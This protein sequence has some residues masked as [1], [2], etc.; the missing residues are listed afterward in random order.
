MFGTGP[1]G[2][3]HI[4]AMRWAVP[5]IEE[6]LLVGR[7]DPCPTDL[8]VVCTCT[9]S[10]VAVL[11]ESSLS[12]GSHCNLVGSYRPNRREVP[13]S[14]IASSTVVVDDLAAA[15]S[16]AGDLILAVADGSWAWA[17]VAGDLH[18][19]VNGRVSRRSGDERTVFKS[20]GLAVQDLAIARL[21]AVRAGLHF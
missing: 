1:Q 13:S 12:A 21:V 17:L 20:V 11:T 2:I 18:A 19:L 10:A 8:D 14:L 4:A 3:A 7:V 9:S 6:V 15:R 5:G 16:E